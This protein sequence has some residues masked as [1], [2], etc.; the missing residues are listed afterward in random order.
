MQTEAHS[1]DYFDELEKKQPWNPVAKR[2]LTGIEGYMQKLRIWVVQNNFNP[3]SLAKACK[4]S[5]GTLRHLYK[6]SWNP[7]F[8]TLRRLETF[9]IMHDEMMKQRANQQSQPKQTASGGTDNS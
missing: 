7:T 1:N 3:N 9:M 6:L 4:M 2:P 8:D 5:E